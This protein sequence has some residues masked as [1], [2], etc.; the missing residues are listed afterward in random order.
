M[1][2]EE[3]FGYFNRNKLIWSGEM[4][5]AADSMFLNIDG[6]R[7]FRNAFNVS[8]QEELIYCRDSSFWN[9]R[10]QGC[11]IT[12]VGIRVIPDNNKPDEMLSVSWEDVDHVTYK[13]EVL[14]FWYESNENSDNQVA[15]HWSYFS[16]N[17]VSNSCFKNLAQHFSR[18]A[19][20]IQSPGDIIDATIDR[21]SKMADDDNPK[22]ADRLG[23]E[24]LG[25]YPECDYRLYYF[26]GYNAL[27]NLKDTELTRRYYTALVEDEYSPET[28]RTMGHYFLAS[29]IMREEGINQSQWWELSHVPRFL[30]SEQMQHFRFHLFMAEKGDRSI[31]VGQGSIVE[32]AASDLLHLESLCAERGFADLSYEQ[33][34]IIC[35]VNSFLGLSEITQTQV[36]PVL[37]PALKRSKCLSFPVGHPVA[38]EVYVCHPYIPGKYLLYENYEIELLEDKLR[39]YCEIMQGLGATEIEVRVESSTAEDSTSKRNVSGSGRLASTADLSGQ[40]DGRA[41]RSEQNRWE[42]TF[43]RHQK[44]SAASAIKVPENTIWLA[45]EPSWQRTIKQRQ[46]G[47]LLSHH[48]SIS[49]S[50]SRVVSGSMA[51]TLKA[52]LKTLFVDLGMEWSATEESTYSNQ[53]SLTLS[54]DVVFGHPAQESGKQEVVSL[55]NTEKEYLEEYKLCLSNGDI[56]SSERRLLNRIAKDLGLTEAQVTR[57]EESVAAVKLTDD[58]QEY[59]NEYKTCLAEGEITSATRRLLDRL[60]QTLN[61]SEDRIKELETL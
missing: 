14:L 49:T 25:K 32:D 38:N 18:V 20:I 42:R 21:L 23:S 61:L 8:E 29:N 47:N 15:I 6:K 36:R 39:E 30:Q 55:S 53:T 56:S 27:R 5:N 2:N 22:E 43:N 34:K 16:K 60:A 48:E 59:L 50:S 3:I 45:G 58:E 37:L 31:D 41:E 13:D 54:V 57:L 11:V 51:H 35:P 7:A 12:D 9:S 26:L 4:L 24:M 44:F 40:Y 52:E 1:V 19:K 28:F 17:F 33:H 46:D 10:N